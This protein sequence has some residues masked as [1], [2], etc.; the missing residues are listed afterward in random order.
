VTLKKVQFI[1]LVYVFFGIAYNTIS[2]WQIQTGHPAWSATDPIAGNIFM[3]VCGVAIFLGLK[4]YLKIYK[5]IMP[6]L[7]FSLAYSG[8]W[9]HIYAFIKDPRVI[10]Y[11][12][13]GTWLGVVA[14]N[15]FGVMVMAW[16][17]WLAF[18]KINKP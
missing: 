8:W 18:T 14:V 16:G 1:E 15:S 3:L 2:Y 4:G 6:F 11:A 7:T 5:Y 17:T 13:F 10:E 9:L 12:S